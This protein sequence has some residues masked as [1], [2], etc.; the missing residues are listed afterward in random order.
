MSD[1]NKSMID[2]SGR[3]IRGA[4]HPYVLADDLYAMVPAQSYIAGYRTGTPAG[5][6]TADWNMGTWAEANYYF[7]EGAVHSAWSIVIGT[8]TIDWARV[9]KITWKIDGLFLDIAAGLT[10]KVTKSKNNSTFPAGT[11]IRDDWDTVAAYTETSDVTLTIEW[12][13]NGV[14]PTSLEF[15]L[16]FTADEGSNDGYGGATSYYATSFQARIV[17]N[18]AA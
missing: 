3:L 12:D 17:Y 15:A 14:E 4:T 16:M 8:N 18:L 2:A 13:I 6:W 7:G 11:V 1:A 5:Q 10:V 9:K